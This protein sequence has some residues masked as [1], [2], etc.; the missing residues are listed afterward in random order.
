MRQSK[1]I[2]QKWKGSKHFNIFFSV[3][4]SCSDQTII[5]EMETGH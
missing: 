4:F 2:N 1:E 5:S 3:M